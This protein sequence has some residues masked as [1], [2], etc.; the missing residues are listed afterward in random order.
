MCI[1]RCNTSSSRIPDSSDAVVAL[2]ASMQV[3]Q[4]P[5]E[6][7][8]GTRMP[9]HQRNE[10]ENVKKRREWKV[11]Y[12]NE[13]CGSAFIGLTEPHTHKQWSERYLLA[14]MA[15]N[16]HKRFSAAS[17]D[18]NAMQQNIAAGDMEDDEFAVVVVELP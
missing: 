7:W 6:W 18:N 9:I 13:V 8:L 1:L 16:L 17:L 5:D 3:K 10:N 4:F 12:R 15:H 2:A 11:H 14:F